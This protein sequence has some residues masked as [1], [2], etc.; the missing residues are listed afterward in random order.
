MSTYTV[1][2][3][4]LKEVQKNA[5]GI[6]QQTGVTLTGKYDLATY[7]ARS[8][9]GKPRLVNVPL[10]ATQFDLQFPEAT[11]LR[12]FNIHLFEIKANVVPNWFGVAVVDGIT[13]FSIPHLFFH[14]EPSQAGY[15]DNAYQRKDQDDKW[16]GLFWYVIHWGFQ[17]AGSD[18]LQVVIMPYFTQAVANDGSN[19]MF[20]TEWEDIV[21]QILTQLRDTYMAAKNREYDNP[22]QITNLV[23]SCFSSGIHYANAFVRRG[24]HVGSYLREAFDLDGNKSIGSRHLSLA[25]AAETAFTVFSYDQKTAD[26]LDKMKVEASA[27]RFHLPK[28]RWSQHPLAP[29]NE[30][31]VHYWMPRRMAHH[32]LKVSRYGKVQ[33]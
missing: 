32:A 30:D 9:L 18:K 7:G 17:L 25:W 10:V 29:A 15:D 27:R 31:V 24:R 8:G 16:V 20:L 4:E 19:G 1:S 6:I 2:E 28:D 22:Q 13:N 33:P 5:S 11:T 3:R 21:V 23:V 26:D 14:P 12:N